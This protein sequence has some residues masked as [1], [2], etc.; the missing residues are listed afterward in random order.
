MSLEPG[1]FVVGTPIGNLGDITRRAVEV[2]TQA[3]ALLAE[4]TRRARA[5]LSHLGIGGKE[6]LRIDAN[7][8][9]RDL[10]RAVERLR[11]GASV[12]LITD[13]GMPSVSDPGSALVRLCR[14]HGLGV[15]VVPGA[16]AVTA[17]LALSGWGETGFWFTGFLPRKGEKRAEVLE[18]VAACEPPVV[19]FEAP[20]RMAQT[21]AD[22]AAL[23]PERALLVARELTKKFEETSARTCAEW[24]E[25][26][27]QWRGEV[28]L[29]LGPSP[30]PVAP[31]YDPADLD[32][33]IAR[34]LDL[35]Q[36]ARS[37]SEALAACW[38]L[39]R[40]TIYQ[41]VLHLKSER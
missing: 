25:D 34:R 33:L 1:L 24:A 15:T 13:A 20:Q 7:A 40:R 12:A 4:D 36:T 27:R 5:L 37:I 2:L 39:P 21:L 22:L 29:V 38:K 35:G 41:R 8:S 6:I 23:M 16:S 3:D 9:E 31:E 14:E 28:T 10:E 26:S 11:D 30:A 32:A 17:A 19:L 18:R